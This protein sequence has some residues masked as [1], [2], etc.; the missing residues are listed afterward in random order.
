M[1][2]WLPI[3][4]LCA[5]IV[6]QLAAVTGFIVYYVQLDD[7]IET[8]GTEYRFRIILESVDEDGTIRFY[9]AESNR[10][11]SYVMNDDFRKAVTVTV[12]DDADEYAELGTILDEVPDSGEYLLVDRPN[13]FPV[14]NTY[15]SGNAN[16]YNSTEDDFSSYAYNYL[17]A[18]YE[19]RPTWDTDEEV[20]TTQPE[21]YVTV[22]IYRGHAAITGMY[23]A[24]EDV[25]T[26][27]ALPEPVPIEDAGENA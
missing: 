22:R 19:S 1:K 3:L 2:K 11:Y 14:E 6:L 4:A 27:D 16:L 8:L 9:P 13:A 10:F 20:Y 21:A 18:Y 25:R 5:V 24:G 15:A 26:L 12:P 17:P 7:K 23:I